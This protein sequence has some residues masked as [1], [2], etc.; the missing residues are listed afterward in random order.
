MSEFLPWK[1]EH[2]E[3]RKSLPELNS[4]TALGGLFVVFWCDD[5]PLGHLS[6]P[7]QLLPITPV[8][9]TAMMSPLI[10]KAVGDRIFANSF[11]A[12]L[13]TISEAQTSNE[14]ADLSRLLS[15]EN[16]LEAC[17]RSAG[18]P[19]A[20]GSNSAAST[21]SVVICTRNRP[22]ALKKC[23]ASLRRLS[24]QADEIVVV[25]NNPSSG[26]TPAVTALFPEVR[27]VPESRHGLSAARNTGIRNTAA[28]IIA[29]TDDDV[30]V[31]S[32]WIG[33]IRHIFNSSDVA[34]ST[35]LILPTELAT[36]AQYAF[37][38]NSL[39]WNL[40]YQRLDFNQKFFQDTVKKGVPVW[41][42]GAGANMAFR[43]EVFS[44]VGFFDERLGAGAAGCS[45]DSELWY[46]IL[47][48]GLNCRYDPEA[49]V[50]HTHRSDAN[51]LSE[52]AFN[53]MRG[54]VSALLFQFDRYRHWG[55]IYR[56]YVALPAFFVRLAYRS[57]KFSIA[58]TFVDPG[59]ESF[60]PP[61]RPQIDGT[62]AGYTYYLS[63]RHLPADPTTARTS[64]SA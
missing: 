51:G 29:F 58:R 59:M 64:R 20:A 43:R 52:Q 54:H 31:H 6:I 1:I 17:S 48:A 30:T 2:I 28:K 24:P 26:V 16:P 33:S 32:R 36:R 12:S 9:L 10:A 21:V 22:D 25:D 5:I 46:R 63:H 3:L 60:E 19:V 56:A 55:N 45:E 18:P 8:Q 39:G 40:G 7:A 13:P 14:P 50:F 37:Q 61:L 38:G 53:Y 23:L 35:G 57:L 44:R 4:E 62:L 15:L 47:A 27:C 42:I 49:V 41:R 11:R 34:A